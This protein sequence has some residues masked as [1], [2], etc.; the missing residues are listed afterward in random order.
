MEMTNKGPTDDNLFLRGRKDGNAM[1]EEYNNPSW[2]GK[3]HDKTL[4]KK[5]GSLN[6]VV[7]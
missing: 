1:K 4:T 3:L 6:T 5:E 7:F 2:G